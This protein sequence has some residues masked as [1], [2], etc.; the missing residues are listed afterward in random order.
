MLSRWFAVSKNPPVP[1]VDASRKVRGDA[2]RAL[3]VVSI[4][5]WSD[6]PSLLSRFGSTCT[7]SCRSRWPQIETF[8]TPGTPRS[9]GRIVH[10]ASTDISIGDTVVDESRIIMILLVDATGCSICGVDDTFGSPAAWVRRSCTTCR[11][12]SRS[13]PE[14]KISSIDESPGIDSDRMVSSH[15]TPASRS[16]S[17]GTVMSCS[18]SGADSPRAS[19]WTWTVGGVN[20]GSESI[21]RRAKLP[22]PGEDHDA[23]GDRDDP[24]DLES[25]SNDS[26]H[27]GFPG[28]ASGRKLGRAASR[29]LLSSCWATTMSLL[30]RLE[31]VARRPSHRCSRSNPVDDLQA[32]SASPR[33]VC[34]H[35]RGAVR[36]GRHRGG[37]TPRR[38]RR[39]CGS[40]PSCRHRPLTRMPRRTIGEV[41]ARVRCHRRGQR[42]A[43]DREGRA[44]RGYV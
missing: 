38:R 8:A 9:F 17:S 6:S 15:G 1:G 21:L 25:E 26:P 2:H 19:V 7:W 4:M 29:P 36:R 12:C 37:R 30:H 22:E 23:G 10:R 5:S 27:H 34:A 42:L 14:S 35:A 20:S 11:A 33:P 16:C 39:R 44:S 32:Y 13:V 31:A 24:R 41:A 28:Q 18:T 40:A 43:R 3:P